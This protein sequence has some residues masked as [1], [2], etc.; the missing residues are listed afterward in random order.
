MSAHRLLVLATA[1]AAVLLSVLPLVPAEGPAPAPGTVPP[2]S[3]L[4]GIHGLDLP[5][6]LH[7]QRARLVEVFGLLEEISGID[8]DLIGAAPDRLV[9]LDLD[10]TP[11]A[12]ALTRVGMAGG[13]RYQV[14]TPWRVEV[15]PIHRAG[16]QGVTY[17][18]VIESNRRWCSRPIRRRPGKRGSWGR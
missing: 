4:E 11:L 7:F 6:S 16:P 3:Q 1:V 18:V 17:P 10:A 15:R 13:V 14:I 8:F 5:V 9:D 2:G 12:D